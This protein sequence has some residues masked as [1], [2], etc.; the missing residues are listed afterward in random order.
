MFLFFRRGTTARQTR[1]LGRRVHRAAVCIVEP[2]LACN[3]HTYGLRGEERQRKKKKKKE[4]ESN[5][6]NPV[7]QLCITKWIVV[8]TAQGCVFCNRLSDFSLENN[9]YLNSEREKGPSPLY[10]IIHD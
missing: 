2:T 9:T 10:D 1:T 6:P 8:G 7:Y 4:S 3:S 5:T